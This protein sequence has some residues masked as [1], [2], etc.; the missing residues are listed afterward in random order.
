M[1]NVGDVVTT[2]K[3]TVGTESLIFRRVKIDALWNEFRC[4][5]ILPH[6]LKKAM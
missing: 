3:L 4:T 2:L 1:K 5:R 6:I